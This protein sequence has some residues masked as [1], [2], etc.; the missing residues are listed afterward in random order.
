MGGKGVKSGDRRG[1]TMAY[2]SR[3]KPCGVGARIG[4]KTELGFDLLAFLIAVICVVTLQ[5]EARDLIWGL[6]TCSLCVGYASIVTGIVA[7]VVRARG[8]TRIALAAGGLFMLAFFTFHFGMFH[9]VHSVFLNHFFP[10]VGEPRGM[11]NIHAILSTAVKSYWPLVLTTFLSRFS[12]I[13]VAGID[14][15]GK[16]DP[17]TKPYANVIRMHVLIFIFAGLHAARIA[18]LAVYPV[19]ALYFVPWRKLLKVAGARS[20]Q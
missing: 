9:F 1:A 3:R 6:W 20:E 17:F 8:T 11:P 4:G 14:L 19:L 7:T 15:K 5:W 13:P 16:K 2:L 18:Q 10:L 12:D